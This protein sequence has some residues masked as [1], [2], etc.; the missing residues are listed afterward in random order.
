MSDEINV[1]RDWGFNVN[2]S[3]LQA[4]TGKGG[5]QVPEGYYTAVIDDMYVNPDRNAGRVVIK[6]KI[7]DG[8]FAGA[9]RTDGLNMPKSDDDKVRYYWRGLLE[10]AGYTPAQLDNGEVTIGRQALVGRK[11]TFYYVPKEEGNSDRQYDRVTYLTAVEWSQQKQAFE[12][13]G[14]AQ[15]AVAAPAGNG[16]ALGGAAPTG[17]MLGGVQGGGAQPLGGGNPAPAGNLGGGAPAS[18]TVSQGDVLSKLGLQQ[19]AQG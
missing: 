18:N 19:P 3:G 6:L 10:S 8:P 11:V 12:A 17:N 5:A 9:M 2:V 1:N 16:S 15:P 7:A 4:P 14:G 13:A